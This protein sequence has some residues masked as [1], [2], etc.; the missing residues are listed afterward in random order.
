MPQETRKP[1]AIWIFQ[2]KQIP[3]E[4]AN[5]KKKSENH[6]VSVKLGT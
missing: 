2:D 5:C 1:Q 3:Q 4:A 6:R